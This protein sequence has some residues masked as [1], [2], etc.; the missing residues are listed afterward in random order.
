MTDA[1]EFNKILFTG[2]INIIEPGIVSIC[3]LA[4]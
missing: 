3:F 1:Y 2:G 4:A